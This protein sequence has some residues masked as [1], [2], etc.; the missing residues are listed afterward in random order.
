MKS[1]FSR[2]I[3]FI[4]LAW[5]LPA[6][7]YAASCNTEGFGAHGWDHKQR[8]SEVRNAKT[9]HYALV[10]SWSPNYC[11]RVKQDDGSWRDSDKFQCA[12]DNN[13]GW[14][15]HGL[16][17]Q[18][19]KGVSSGKGGKH[20][21][22]CTDGDLPAAELDVMKPHACMSPSATLLQAQWEKHGACAFPTPNAYFRTMQDLSGFVTMPDDF[23]EGKALIQWVQG[24]NAPLKGKKLFWRE[25]AK[26][27]VVCYN[28]QFFPADCK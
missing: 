26:E 28:N 5:L 14:I 12:S 24:N 9:H 20:P 6:T 22:Y 17:P 18:S 7:A 25:K 21:R 23:M 13:F 27:L 16:W 10:Y 4:G 15:V 19:K 3:A 2:V 1:Q 8:S 11:N